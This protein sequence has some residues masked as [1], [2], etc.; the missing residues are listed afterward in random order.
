M[1][2]YTFLF[3]GGMD[4]RR[5][6]NRYANNLGF[7][8][9]VLT[10]KLQYLPENIT[11]M[12][13]DGIS[14]NYDNSIINTQAAK[15]DNFFSKMTEYNQQITK[16]DLFTFV[17]SN[18]GGNDG[19]L[20]TWEDIP[21]YRIEFI[22]AANSIACIKIIILGQCYGGN[23]TYPENKIYNSVILSANAPEQ[24][25]Y[26]KIARD[27]KGK[28]MLDKINNYDEFLYN[29]FSYYN[30]SYPCGKLLKDIKKDNLILSAYKYTRDNDF[31]CNG[32]NFGSKFRQETPY[33][34]NNLDINAKIDISTICL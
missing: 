8:Y 16:N 28:Y 21:I 4:N 19:E 18:H 1:V 26:A 9:K 23:Y 6:Y 3:S 25:S 32:I 5:N 10:E 7:V 15:K 14:I 17:A 11:V 33:I 2:K 13:A 30:G 34:K 20:C 29:F 31:L 22:N 12:Y 24:P 27:L